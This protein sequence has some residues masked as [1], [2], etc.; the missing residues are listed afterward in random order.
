MGLKI[1]VFG[2]SDKG[3]VRTNN[4]DNY[5]IDE[6]IKLFV[7]ADGAGGHLSGE[8]ASKLAV[9]VIPEQMKHMLIDGQKMQIGKYNPKFSEK[10]NMLTTAVEFANRVIFEAS[11]K[12]PKNYGMATTCV[13]VLFNDDKT[14]SYTN[15]GDSRI[16]LIRDNKMSQITNDHSLVQEQVRQGIISAEEAEK[17][18]YK[19]ILTRALG[20]VENVEIDTNEIA[21]NNGDYLLLCTDGLLRMVDDPVIIRSIIENKEPQKIVSELVGLA[22]EKG[23]KD[24]IT[25]V[26]CQITREEKLFNKLWSSITR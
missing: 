24:N 9:E 16:Y 21:V 3:M 11:Q 8:M 5:C 15:V 2:K 12:Y 26:L 20:S 6:S 17:V 1:N 10:A 4:E 25:V 23:G 18:E 13:A 14:I 19:N 22:N 7:V